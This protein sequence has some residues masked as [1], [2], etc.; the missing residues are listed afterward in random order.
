MPLATQLQVESAL[1]TASAVAHTRIH[2]EAGVRGIVTCV[3]IVL[4]AVWMV[5]GPL[6]CCSAAAIAV[7]AAVTVGY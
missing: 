7:A 5:H 2:V 3:I 6:L 1:L 4:S